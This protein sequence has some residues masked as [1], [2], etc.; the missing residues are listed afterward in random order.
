[1][2]G[3]LAPEPAGASVTADPAATPDWPGLLTSGEVLLWS[4]R[5]DFT[6]TAIFA[7]SVF[8]FS[9][10]A[11]P[12]VLPV[13]AFPAGAF[14]LFARDAYALTDRRILVRRHPFAGAPRLQSLPRAG[15][16]PQPYWSGGWRGL[17][18]TAPDGS[19]L[20]FRLLN[21]KTMA[22]LI[23]LYAA[24]DGKAPR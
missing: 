20:H 16:W 9:L 19:R 15:T 8:L 5:P 6:G 17:T 13:L 11:G 1:M 18:F 23:A 4:G 22:H 2:S 10:V 7:G 3:L 21:R 14:F 24:P 12:A